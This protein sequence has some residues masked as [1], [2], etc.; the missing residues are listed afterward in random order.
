MGSWQIKHLR[1][2]LQSERALQTEEDALTS[3]ASPRSSSKKTFESLGNYLVGS[4]QK[5]TKSFA[6]Q[7]SSPSTNKISGLYSPTQAKVSGLYNIN[8]PT[9]TS[10]RISLPWEQK[11]ELFDAR[12]SINLGLK[13]REGDS[14]TASQAMNFFID[15]D[16]QKNKRIADLEQRL[17]TYDPSFDG[18]TSNRTSRIS[19]RQDSQS[20]W[21]KNQGDNHQQVKKR[22]TKDHYKELISGTEPL[23]FPNHSRYSEDHEFSNLMHQACQKMRPDNHHLKDE[24]KNYHEAFIKHRPTLRK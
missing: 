23:K 3:F 19:L 8:S 12:G 17:I 11:S 24:M 20:D 21:W 15:K 4:P 7:N 9:A 1:M 22:R 5:P 18:L 6:S 16:Y 13:K 2:K 10:D 14:E